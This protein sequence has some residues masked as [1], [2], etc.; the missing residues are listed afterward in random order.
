KDG[1]TGNVFY[2]CGAFSTFDNP[3]QATV[4][5]SIAVPPGKAIFF[6]ILNAESDNLAVPPTHFTEAE[7]RAFNAANLVGASYFASLDG[8]SSDGMIGR[9][10]PP[11]FTYNLPKPKKGDQNIA[12]HFGI[13]Y[14]GPVPGAVSD[15]FWVYLPP[16][17]KKATHTLKFGGML[18]N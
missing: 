5:R 11:F 2:L 18:S 7:L 15:G 8:V 4:E 9:P 17:S 1:Q 10:L 3:L 6:P 12:Q 13:D 14:S 16:L